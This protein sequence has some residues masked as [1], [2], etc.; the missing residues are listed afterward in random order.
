MVNKYGSNR[1]GGNCIFIRNNISYKLVKNLELNLTDCED[2][3]VEITFTHTFK[4]IF[5]SIYRH[6]TH[7]INEF[8]DKLLKNI[9]QFNKNNKRFILA[10]DFNINYLSDTQQ[11]NQYKREIN[12]NGTLQLVKTPTHYSN[13]NKTFSLIDHIYTNIDE[14]KTNTQ[15]ISFDISDHL[16]VVTVVATKK[17]E[18]RSYVKKKP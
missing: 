18:K 7:R 4:F 2:L 14:N 5:G 6:P 3:W 12:S 15:C 16:P 13:Q 8:Q 9:E 17:I 10:G 1:A 11:V